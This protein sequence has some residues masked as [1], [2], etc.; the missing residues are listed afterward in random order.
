M[1]T[2]RMSVPIVIAGALQKYAWGDEEFIPHLLGLESDGPQAELWFGSHPLAPA[3]AE[4]SGRQQP[5][6][7]LIAADPTALLGRVARYGQLPYLLK[8]LAAARPLSLQVHPSREQAEAGFAAEEAQGL[9]RSAPERTYRDPHHKPELLVALTPF[10]AL[11]GFRPL[12]LIRGELQKN[13]ELSGLSSQALDSP[14]G[15]KAW[16]SA[17]FE[18]PKER[19]RERLGALLER[20]HQRDLRGELDPDDAGAW[21]LAARRAARPADRSRIRGSACCIQAGQSR[22]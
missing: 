16:V 9:S 22:S 1:T 20:L 4:L 15:L 21:A 6:D 3:I 7:S 5:L 13:P 8:I 2:Q 11:A 10:R 14:A 19:L 18:T 17:V 12:E